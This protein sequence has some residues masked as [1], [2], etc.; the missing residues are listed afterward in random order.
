MKLPGEL[1]YTH[2]L[3]MRFVG[4]AFEVGVEIPAGRLGALDAK[5]I[6]ELFADA[7]HRTFMHG[8]SVPDPAGL[9]NSS[10][11]GAARRAIDFG[12]SDTVDPAAFTEY[13]RTEPDILALVNHDPNRLL[14]RTASGTLRLSV[15]DVGLAYDL[16]LP[17][18]SEGR[19]LAVLLERRDITGS[20]FTFRVAPDGGDTW[21]QDEDGTPLRTV[22]AIAAIPELYELNIG[23]A[24]IGRAAFDGLSKAVSDM[25]LLMQEARQGI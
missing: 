13:L 23:H 10:L 1:V 11:D 16:D 3:D 6:A 25:R 12:A 19:D 7:H 5:Y 18:T 4:Q 9:F 8:A 24:I 21:T 14:G 20:S 15:D 17:D 22:K 2:T